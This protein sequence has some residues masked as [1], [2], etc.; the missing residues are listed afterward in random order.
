VVKCR[1]PDNRD[2]LPEESAACAPF[3]SRQIRLLKPRVIVTVG[4]VPTQGLLKSSEP[5]GKLRGRFVPYREAPGTQ[6][7]PLLPTYH[8]SALLRDETLKRPAWEDLKLLREK[9][10]SLDETYA[11]E[12]RERRR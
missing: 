4:R 1:P 7:I 12:C 11:G 3:L 10:F 8:P 2:P 5:I 6:E 9:L